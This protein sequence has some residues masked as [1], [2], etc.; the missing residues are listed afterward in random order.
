MMI[1]E[2]FFEKMMNFF[3]IYIEK[4]NKLTHTERKLADFKTL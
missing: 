1:H 3:L 2:N 4:K